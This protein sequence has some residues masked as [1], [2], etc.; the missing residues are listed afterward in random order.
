MSNSDG[1]SL[2]EGRLEQLARNSKAI[3]STS[4]LNPSLWEMGEN[5]DDS[6]IVDNFFI[7]LSIVLGAAHPVG[8]KLIFE[9]ILRYVA[10][11]FNIGKPR[12]GLAGFPMP[13]NH[14]RRYIPRGT[15][16]AMQV[17]TLCALSAVFYDSEIRK[18]CCGPFSPQPLHE[19]LKFTVGFR[20]WRLEAKREAEQ[21]G[22]WFLKH[23]H[24]AS[25][26]PDPSL[27]ANTPPT[28][29]ALRRGSEAANLG[30]IAI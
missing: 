2:S 15:Q 9:K 29:P 4:A 13:A 1:A 3:G 14:P 18:I 26:L 12:M 17:Q 5:F 25:A 27:V 10:G 22:P 28:L 6:R 30:I 7:W 16:Q 8:L 19:F 20:L 11:R 24:R 21:V 23:L